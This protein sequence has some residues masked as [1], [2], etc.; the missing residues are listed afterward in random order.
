MQ[1][2]ERYLTQANYATNC[3][4]QRQRPARMDPNLRVVVN[5]EL[6]YFC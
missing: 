3:V 4:V 5:N 2:P 1:A 6:F